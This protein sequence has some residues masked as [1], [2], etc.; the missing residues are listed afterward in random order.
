M[1]GW[2]TGVID[3]V[4]GFLDA[5]NPGL[6]TVGSGGTEAALGPADT[7]VNSFGDSGSIVVELDD[8]IHDGP[9]DDFAVFENGFFTVDGCFCELG[10]VEV[11]SDGAHFAE[12]ES[13][14]LNTAGPGDIDPTDYRNFAG[15]HPSSGSPYV[16]TGFDL[17]ELADHPLVLS[18]DVNLGGIRFIRIT[19]VIGDGSTFDSFDNPVYDPY[20]TAVGTGGFDLNAVG[21][22]NLPEPGSQALMAS[23][24]LALVALGRFRPGRDRRRCTP[25][26]V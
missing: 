22:I 2:A 23:G 12:F 16:G 15:K 13:E 1:T 10:F 6:G 4:P 24:V 17:S 11:S 25:S 7:E 26:I 20:P 8:F 19:D 14:T 5:N 18:G 21:I 3:F 9:G